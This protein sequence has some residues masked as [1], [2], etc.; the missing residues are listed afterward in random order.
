MENDHPPKYKWVQESIRGTRLETRRVEN[1]ELEMLDGSVLNYHLIDIRPSFRL[2]LGETNYTLF[3]ETFLDLS[4]TIRYIYENHPLDDR[5]E[6]ALV[7]Y[8]RNEN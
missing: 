1:L 2:R 4:A 3:T 8:G 6:V 5:E 7:V